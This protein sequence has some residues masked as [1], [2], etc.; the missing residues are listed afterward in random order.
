MCLKST[1]DPLRDLLAHYAAWDFRH[2]EGAFPDYLAENEV[3][4]RLSMR[5]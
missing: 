1:K 5:L 4:T 2:G 3:F